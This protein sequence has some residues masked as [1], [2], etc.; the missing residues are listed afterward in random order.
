MTQKRKPLLDPNRHFNG[1]PLGRWDPSKEKKQDSEPRTKE[2]KPNT[3]NPGPQG[4]G[5]RPSDWIRGPLLEVLVEEANG[6]SME[7]AIALA[8]K[9]KRII[10]SNKRLDQALVGSDEWRSIEKVFPCW[11]GT[12]TAYE[13][14]GKPFGEIVEYTDD[15]TGLK[16]LFEVPQKYKGKK[17]C[18]LVCEHPDFSLETKGDERI[19]RAAKIDL[20]EKFPAN[21][22]WYLVDSKHGI[23]FGDSVKFSDDTRYLY[24]IEKRVGPVARGYGDCGDDNRRNVD[25]DDWP[26]GGLGGV[27]E[28]PEKGAPKNQSSGGAS[29]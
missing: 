7:E 11:T 14:V 4:Q 13:E 5:P 22:D 24:R 19:I 16:Y 10:A 12:M 18:I 23:P 28:A 20:I 1:K 3:Q 2:T 17:D 9:E 6:V 15:N 27:V 26:S 8:N 29:K 21:V 25:I